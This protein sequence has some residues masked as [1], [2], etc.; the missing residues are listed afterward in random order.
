[1]I[2]KNE[3]QNKG[4]GMIRTAVTASL[5]PSQVLPVVG[6]VVDYTHSLI[7]PPGTYG[8]CVVHSKTSLFFFFGLIST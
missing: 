3:Q 7:A 6:A 8:M 2:I 5:E 4:V 1:M